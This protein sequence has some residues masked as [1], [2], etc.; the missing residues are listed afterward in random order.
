MNLEISEQQNV[1]DLYW[2]L[3][4]SDPNVQINAAVKLITTLKEFQTEFIKENEV[5]WVKMVDEY[6]PR[7]QYIV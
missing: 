4:H 7:E 1:M 2:E 6:K 3:A 5:K